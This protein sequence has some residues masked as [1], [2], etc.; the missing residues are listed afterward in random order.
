MIAESCLNKVSPV[1]KFMEHIYNYS[2]QQEPFTI[3]FVF[4]EDSVLYARYI[5]L[6]TLLWFR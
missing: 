4:V 1:N 5:Y 6:R 3:T 2:P